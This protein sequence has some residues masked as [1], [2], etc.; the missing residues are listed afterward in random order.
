MENHIFL[1]VAAVGHIQDTSNLTKC[2]YLPFETINQK[3]QGPDTI[4]VCATKL[5][6]MLVTIYGSIQLAI[7]T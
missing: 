7:K 2:L 1:D 5:F 4:N 6:S 3:H